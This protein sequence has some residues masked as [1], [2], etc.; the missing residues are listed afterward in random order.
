MCVKISFQSFPSLK[1]TLFNTECNITN[2]K[3]GMTSKTADRRYYQVSAKYAFNIFHL[4]ILDFLDSPKTPH[5]QY[6]IL[7]QNNRNRLSL[8]SVIEQKFCLKKVQTRFQ[9]MTL[10]AWLIFPTAI[11]QGA[12]HVSTWQYITLSRN[13]KEMIFLWSPNTQHREGN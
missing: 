3:L 2:F 11:L 8:P 1:E 4:R 10:F 13:K 7:L 12:F 6:W 5:R 9:P